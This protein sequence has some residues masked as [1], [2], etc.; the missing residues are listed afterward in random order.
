M[1]SKLIKS[2]FKNAF[3]AALTF[4]AAF[5]SNAQ[6][7]TTSVLSTNGYRVNITLST[8]SL[9]KPSTCPWGYNYNTSF[10]YNITFS[11]SNIPSALY[12]LQA[13]LN[14][15]SQ[16]NFASLPLSG[17]AGSVTTGSNPFQNNTN[18]ATV[19]PQSLN[20]N[21]YT[22]TINGPG[23]PNQTIT[24]NNTVALPVTLVDF[25]A[26]NINARATISWKTASEKNSAYFVVER[27][28]DGTKWD[29]V[30]RIE[31]AKNSSTVQSYTTTDD[32]PVTGMAFYRLKQVDVDGQSFLSTIQVLNF[33]PAVMIT[34]YPNPATTEF[35]LEGDNMD[36]AEITVM[37]C[38]GKTLSLN[39]H[40][41]GSK[42]TYQT[43]GLENGIYFVSVNVN[44]AVEKQKFTVR[45]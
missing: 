21:S 6:Q 17:G 45:N 28:V 27:S 41:E 30:K 44:G 22:L 43:A 31:S 2:T 39:S 4:F 33:K 3:A 10:N 42:I 18:C 1:N 24:M 12:T 36:N 37:D 5:Q 11:G 9:I 35:T 32:Q 38:M 26:Q 25:T 23:I 19:T 29:A 20:C 8:I 40:V 15:G 14:C 16:G 34:L 7:A 13:V